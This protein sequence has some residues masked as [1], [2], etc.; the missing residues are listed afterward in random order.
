MILEGNVTSKEKVQ[1][2]NSREEN[3]DEQVPLGEE[4]AEISTLQQQALGVLKQMMITLLRDGTSDSL[5]Y[6]VNL[7]G[8]VTSDGLLDSHADFGNG[9]YNDH[10]FHYGYL[11]YACAILGKLDQSFVDDYANQVDAIYLDI[12]HDS[13]LNSKEQINGVFYPGSRHKVWFDGHSF[14]SGL[15]PFGNGKSQ[16]SSSEAV[17]AYYGAYLWSLVRNG[18]AENPESD[19]SPQ[20]DFARLLLATEI[21]GA[22]TY[23]H[24]VPPLLPKNASN[25]GKGAEAAT[26]YTPQFSKNYMVGNLGML[27]AVC[28][29]WFGTAKLYVH[30]INL[31]PVTAITGELFGKKYSSLEFKEILGP[32]GTVEA[33]WEGFVTADHAISDPEAAWHKAVD[34]FSPTLDAGLSKTQLLYWI[35]TRQGFNAS[36]VSID[37]GS[38]IQSGQSNNAG[39]DKSS[40][41]TSTQPDDFT[42]NKASCSNSPS[43]QELDLRGNCCP[44]NGGIFLDC[45][46]YD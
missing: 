22:K 24:M 37:D 11:L 30:M 45:C 31:I 39:Q 2:R 16:E 3:N 9:R 8:I 14:A 25:G 32:L 15:F 10:H 27:D 19:T 7:G 46:S 34:L 35:A 5:V 41:M 13:N 21:R 23:W 26:V 29:T 36:S 6:D 33:A 40:Y 43:C 28:T 12:A 4:D 38:R 1:K 20:T 17:N 42:E 18:A 44:T